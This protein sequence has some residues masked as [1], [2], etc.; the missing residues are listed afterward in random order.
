[1]ETSLPFPPH[2][3]TEKANI[4]TNVNYWIFHFFIQYSFSYSILRIWLYIWRSKFSFCSC[5]TH[6]VSGISMF[7]SFLEILPL[8]KNTVFPYRR[9]WFGQLF[10]WNPKHKNFPSFKW[11]LDQ[12]KNQPM[13]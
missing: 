3:K 12:D 10:Y 7:S 11:V 9:Q 1:M 6:L 4:I 8:P 13:C 2:I 5:L